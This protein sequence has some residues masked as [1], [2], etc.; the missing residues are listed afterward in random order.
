[1]SPNR[2][3]ETEATL[4]EEFYWAGRMVVYVNGAL[5]D[6]SFEDEVAK[7]KEHAK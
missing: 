7:A 4:V 3:F 1:M 5:S 2:T 6:L